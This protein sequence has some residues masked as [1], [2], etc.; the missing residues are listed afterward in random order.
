[1]SAV[2]ALRVTSLTFSGDRAPSTLG[3]IRIARTQDDSRE[4]TVRRVAGGSVR[5][6]D[7]A[8]SPAIPPRVQIL[9]LHE[10]VWRGR[11]SRNGCQSPATRAGLGN[12]R[13]AG[14]RPTGWSA[15]RYPCRTAS[16][17]GHTNNPD[18]RVRRTARLPDFPWTVRNAGCFESDANAVIL[19]GANRQ[20]AMPSGL[21]Y[22]NRCRESG[23]SGGRSGHPAPR[24]RGLPAGGA[25]PRG[26]GI[27]GD[28]ARVWGRSRAQGW[29]V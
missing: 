28:D 17:R 8:G 11:R 21:T 26:S 7:L 24:P 4:L 12:L 29:R 22:S 15:P 23:G 14:P 20:P 16:P 5:Q 1:M 2:Q 19:R 27:A 3:M 10:R 13:R 25:G 9:M 6:S 18:S